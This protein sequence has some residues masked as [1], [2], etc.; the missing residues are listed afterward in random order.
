VNGG[1][2]QVVGAL[3]RLSMAV[4]YVH[5]DVSRE[6]DL[7]PQQSVMMCAIIHSPVGMAELADYLHIEKSTLTG[8]VDRAE[9]RGLVARSQDPSDRRAVRVALTPQGREVVTAFQHAI[10]KTLTEQLDDLPASVRRQL[11]TALP[12]IADTYWNSLSSHDVPR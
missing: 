6:H 1:S 10:T 3:I 9:Q 5:Q 12:M 11:Q 7:T 4:Q 2:E 8:L